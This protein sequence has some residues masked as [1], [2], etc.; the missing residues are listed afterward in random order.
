MRLTFVMYFESIILT[1]SGVFFCSRDLNDYTFY[2]LHSFFEL[3]LCHQYLLSIY[4]SP[5]SVLTLE[6]V[7][8]SKTRSL[9]LTE[10]VL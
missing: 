4:C 1:F 3:L 6:R 7:A 2:K 5:G 10:L 8:V 9:L